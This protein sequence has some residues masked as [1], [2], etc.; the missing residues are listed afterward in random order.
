MNTA[1]ND[2]YVH[3]IEKLNITIGSLISDLINPNMKVYSYSEE[4]NNEIWTIAYIPHNNLVALGCRDSSIKIFNPNTQE[5][6]F[7]LSTHSGAITGLKV[8]LNNKR[9]ASASMNSQVKCWDLTNYKELNSLD[10]TPNTPNS[11]G[12]SP[13]GNFIIIGQSDGEI[14]I[15]EVD[16]FGIGKKLKGHL[17]GVNS[18][19]LS[20]DSKIIASGSDD[21]TVRLWS[22]N[23]ISEIFVF[24]GHTSIVSLVQITADDKFV[25]SGSE[26]KTVRLWS[27]STKTLDF[28]YEGHV[29]EIYCLSLSL[30]SSIIASGS[31]DRSVKVWSIARKALDFSYSDHDGYVSC[32]KILD[33]QKY[34][35]SGCYQTILLANIKEKRVEIIFE[36]HDKFIMSLTANLDCSRLYSVSADKTFKMWNIQ[37][38]Q[39]LAILSGHTSYVTC[40][41]ISPDNR[42]LITGSWDFTVKLWSLESFK[43]IYTFKGHK[44]YVIAV[45]ISSNSQYALS[46]SWDSTIR[47]WDILRK[48]EVHIFSEHS[49]VIFA[50]V[51]TKNFKYA[52]SGS[53]NGELIIW[54]IKEKSKEFQVNHQEYIASLAISKDDKYIISA[55]GDKTVKMIN[56]HTKTEEKTF[57]HDINVYCIEF[58]YDPLCVISGLNN[59]EIWAWGSSSEPE[60]MHAHNSKVLFLR[61][62]SN[63]EYLI[64]GSSEAMIKVWN[65]EDYHEYITFTLQSSLSYLVLCPNSKLIVSA[66]EAGIIQFWSI[67]EKREEMRILAHTEKIEGIEFTV[68]GMYIVSC[69]KDKLCKVWGFEDFT[70]L[71]LYQ[72]KDQGSL[73]YSIQ[74]NDFSNIKRRKSVV[75]ISLKTDTLAN[76]SCYP[77]LHYYGFRQRLSKRALP[78]DSDCQ[79]LL[80]LGVNAG[81]IY[82]F[83]GLDKHLYQAL[84]LGCPI[85]KDSSGNSPLHYALSKDSQKSIDSILLFMIT[86]SKDPKNYFK[87]LEYCHAL[88]DDINSIIQNSSIHLLGFLESIFVIIK[89]EELPIS[90]T[91]F[92]PPL[93]IT[94]KYSKILFENFL[95]DQKPAK[96]YKETFIEFRQSS[97]QFCICNGAKLSFDLLRSIENTKNPAIYNSTLI[98]TILDYKW[99]SMRGIMLFYT[100]LVWI[101]VIFMIPLLFV[102]FRSA[103]GHSIF[104]I[105]NIILI[106]PELF[107]A[108]FIGLIPYFKAWRNRIDLFASLFSIFW[109]IIYHYNEVTKS[110]YIKWIM[111]LTNFIRG[112]SGFRAFNSTRYYIR[113]IIRASTDAIPFIII[114]V[115]TTLCFGSLF[116]SSFDVVQ[117]MAFIA[118]WKAPFELS[119]GSFYN[120]NT[121]DLYYFTFTIAAFFNVVMML[122]LLISILSD[123]FNRF[124]IEAEVID[125]QEKLE[126]ILEMESIYLFFRNK[127]NIGYLQ[128]CESVS[129]KHKESQLNGKIVEIQE[130]IDL[131]QEEMNNKFFRLENFIV[132]AERNYDALSLK[133]D[134]ILQNPSK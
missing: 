101:C 134:R 75:A 59:G 115:Y 7:D 128:L 42:Y 113:L 108:R 80:P 19:A 38:S 62:S 125:Y 18:I 61:I 54:N 111:V 63:R 85:R 92:S 28:V 100:I 49:T 104:M 57:K 67:S 103:I 29:G 11:I 90:I 65:L 5:E 48:E 47:L 110:C 20:S 26:D 32:I 66:T 50:L 31:Q 60:I 8:S 132:N 122:N 15:W 94:S 14:I 121:M 98:R 1:I 81:H 96:K 52:A 116:A 88:R 39:S 30:D 33:N 87:I 97:F 109:Q 118:L 72:N 68:N 70:S 22:V 55:S 2:S 44:H 13:D 4:F 71:I 77:Y 40:L 89:N 25:V 131:V 82:A 74:E 3:P 27:I 114:I 34:I 102:D 120:T 124:N 10:L 117:S 17:A 99:K 37:D 12:I 35:A 51:A 9:L 6:V 79:L 43:E 69:S 58:L 112:L 84:T 126:F 76:L 83:L 93:I 127:S 107:Q 130:K 41:C 16:S 36:G 45:C 123:S 129:R 91:E 64:S 73:D 133:I 24:I 105:L 46:A 119:L 53:G 56:L 95:K 78:Y 21:K 106:L 23:T 86:F